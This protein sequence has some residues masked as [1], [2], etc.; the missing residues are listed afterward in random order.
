MTFHVAVAQLA[1]RRSHNPQVV[2]SSLTCH[3]FDA[4]STRMMGKKGLQRCTWLGLGGLL[5]MVLLECVCGFLLRVC[6]CVC[7]RA[8]LC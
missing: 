3:I 6:V 5:G 2:S 7:V 4:P 8:C 1:A